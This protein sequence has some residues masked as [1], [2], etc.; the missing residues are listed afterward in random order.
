MGNLGEGGVPHPP[1]TRHVR[2]RALPIVIR[3]V[4]GRAGVPPAAQNVVSLERDRDPQRGGCGDPP[5]RL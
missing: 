1:V 3:V 2:S 4:V 5:S